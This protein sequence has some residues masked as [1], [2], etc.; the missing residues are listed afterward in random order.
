MFLLVNSV[1]VSAVIALSQKRSVSEVWK[2]NTQGAIRYDFLA[3]PL[4]MA[5]RTS[6]IAILGLRS[7]SHSLFLGLRQLYK[8]N[9]QLET[10]TE[11]L[12]Q[13]MVA[14]IEAARSIHVGPLAAVSEYAKVVARAAGFLQSDRS[15]VWLL[16]HCCMTLEKCTKSSHQFF[17]SPV[18]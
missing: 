17:G 5:L 9:W 14:A 8:T 11:E 7:A 1:S 15:I 13:L 6:I 18:A 12:L 10:I 4:Y 2:E 16:R 3:L